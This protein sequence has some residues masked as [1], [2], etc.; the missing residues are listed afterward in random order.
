MDNN[1]SLY[2]QSLVIDYG[3]GELSLERVP[4]S[5]DNNPISVKLH[6]VVE[7]QDLLY[8]ADLY[9]G[10]EMLWWKIADANNLIGD[11][12]ELTA[13]EMLKIPQ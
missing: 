1:N 10:D 11:I 9:L 2:N 7:G 13:G 3:N 12:F 5:V 6:Q 8:L 4:S